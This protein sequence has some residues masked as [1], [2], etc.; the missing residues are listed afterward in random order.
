[1]GLHQRAGHSVVC[2][3][4]LLCLLIHTAGYCRAGALALGGRL[5]MDI[6]NN[7]TEDGFD[8]G[9][10]FGEGARPGRNVWGGRLLF[11][12]GG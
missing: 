7:Q 4:A 12:W 1:M 3:T 8:V 6:N 10:G 5:F 9:R 11:V 2:V